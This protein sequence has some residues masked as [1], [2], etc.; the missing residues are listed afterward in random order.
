MDV[1]TI[2]VD[3]SAKLIDASSNN[4]ITAAFL[5]FLSEKPLWS[6]QKPHL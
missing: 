6:K 5:L 2:A 1:S 4:T 3:Q